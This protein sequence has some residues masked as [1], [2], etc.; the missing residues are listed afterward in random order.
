MSKQGAT[1]LSELIYVLDKEAIKE[2]TVRL[3]DWTTK[4]PTC[5]KANTYG[6]IQVGPCKDCGGEDT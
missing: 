3:R 4:C 2:G 5:G 6:E 1:M